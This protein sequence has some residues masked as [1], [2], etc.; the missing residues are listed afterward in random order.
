MKDYVGLLRKELI[1]RAERYAA[2]EG[3]EE[4]VYRS[5]GTMPETRDTFTTSRRSVEHGGRPDAIVSRG[6]DGPTTKAP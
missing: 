4:Y 5:K 6:M 3:I 1:A 2:Q